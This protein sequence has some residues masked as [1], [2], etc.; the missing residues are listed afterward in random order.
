MLSSPA[1]KLFY[2]CDSTSGNR[3][4]ICGRRLRER[5][6]QPTT[7]AELGAAFQEGTGSNT[8]LSHQ[9]ATSESWILGE[10]PRGY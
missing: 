6:R 4:K 7:V 3:I 10:P 8:L 2:F 5:Q 9:H 1:T